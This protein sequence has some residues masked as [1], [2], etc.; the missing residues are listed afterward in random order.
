MRWKRTSTTTTRNSPA[1]PPGTRYSPSARV[2][3]RH[4]LPDAP[5]NVDHADQDSVRGYVLSNGIDANGR[6]IGFIYAGDPA[7]ADGAQVF[8][9]NPRV[10]TSINAT[11]LNAGLTYPAFYD[12]LPADL[13]AHL[14]DVSRAARTAGAGIR[15]RSTA[16]PNSAATIPDLAALEQL[17]IW[18][19]LFRRIVPYLAAGFTDFDGFDTWLRADPVNRDDSLL[20]LADPPRAGNLHDVVTA[21]GHTIQLTLWP[22]EFVIAPDPAPPGTTTGPRPHAAG[23]VVILAALPDPAGVDRGHETVTL[24]NTTG[25]EIVRVTPSSCPTPTAPPS[26][27]SPTPPATSTPAAPS[28]S[29]APKPHPWTTSRRSGRARGQGSRDRHRV[30]GLT[31]VQRHPPIILI[32]A[33]APPGERVDTGRRHVSRHRQVVQRRERLRL[34]HPGR[35]RPRRVRPLLGDHRHRLPVPRGEPEGHLHRQ[36][37]RQGTAGIGRHR[38]LTKSRRTGVE[39]TR[40]RSSRRRTS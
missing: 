25:S 24:I 7:E 29:A 26:T 16:D 13:R 31:V 8:L 2:H 37:G 34:H 11:L 19:K 12:T 36:P 21:A 10:D 40:Y 22:E 39:P 32:T 28:A 23:D 15:A 17:V 14:A 33:R 30:G 6:M 4:V 35:R 3:R 9:D 27:P 20:L 5:N 38:R 1:P 18:P